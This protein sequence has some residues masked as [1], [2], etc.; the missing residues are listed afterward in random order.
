MGVFLSASQERGNREVPKVFP[1]NEIKK[2]AIPG[3]KRRSVAEK[4]GA[5][6]AKESFPIVRKR[7]PGAVALW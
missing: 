5:P 4:G 6:Q 7:D 2:R 3:M 1:S